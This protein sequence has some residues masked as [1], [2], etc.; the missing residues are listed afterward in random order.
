[1]NDN[2]L[3]LKPYDQ[4]T[5][6][7][8]A[9]ERRRARVFLQFTDSDAVQQDAWALEDDLEQALLDNI[10]Q[11]VRQISV[12]VPEDI[13]SAFQ[14]GYQGYPKEAIWE[15]FATRAYQTLGV[16]IPF[17]TFNAKLNKLFVEIQ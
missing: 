15:G 8:Q 12:P 10:Q 4:A 1:M 11:G 6:A 5:I 3:N 13:S 2:A 16:P 9:L 7:C 14:V 17:M